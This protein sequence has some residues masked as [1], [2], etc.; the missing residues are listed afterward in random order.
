MPASDAFDVQFSADGFLATERGG[1]VFGVYVVSAL[2]AMLLFWVA[3]WQVVF[4]AVAA[5]A[6]AFAW[7]RT[8]RRVIRAGRDGIASEY[9]VL[10]RRVCRKTLGAAEIQSISYEDPAAVFWAVHKS[11]VVVRGRRTR[12]VFA[13]GVPASDAKVLVETMQR[14]LALPA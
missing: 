6:A 14:V 11:G 3:W 2:G 10:G 4:C 1:D 7:S 9:V 13:F 5:A 8:G 12:L